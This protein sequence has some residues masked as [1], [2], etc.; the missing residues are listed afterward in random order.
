MYQFKTKAP[1]FNLTQLLSF[2]EA[3]ATVLNNIE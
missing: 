3:L 2:V 1:S